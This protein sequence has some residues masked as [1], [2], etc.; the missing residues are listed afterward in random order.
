MRRDLDLEVQDASFTVII[1]PF[2][3]VNVR[4]QM[5][6]LTLQVLVVLSLVLGVSQWT[7]TTFMTDG[8][9]HHVRI[10]RQ[11]DLPGFLVFRSDH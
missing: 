10:L 3:K 5:P 6:L 4:Y 8:V 9:G 2:A 11:Y 7:Q 1:L